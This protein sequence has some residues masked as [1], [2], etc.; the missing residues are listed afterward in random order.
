MIM[1]CHVLDVMTIGSVLNR[2]LERVPVQQQDSKRTNQL[3]Y[4]VLSTLEKV[5]GACSR[6]PSSK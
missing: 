5:F 1:S 6:A 2:I 3:P 4:W